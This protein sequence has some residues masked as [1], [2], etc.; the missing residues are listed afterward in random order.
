M[1]KVSREAVELMAKVTGG[2]FYLRQSINKGMITTVVGT[3]SAK[4]LVEVQIDRSQ[5]PEGAAPVVGNYTWAEFQAA[6]ACTPEIEIGF[7]EGELT[8]NGM[9]LTETDPPAEVFTHT[10]VKSGTRLFCGDKDACP[11]DVAGKI[12]EILPAMEGTI[13]VIEAPEGRLCLSRNGVIAIVAT[14][15]VTEDVEELPSEE[16]MAAVDAMIRSGA[17]TYEEATAEE[18]EEEAE[19]TEE[20][21]FDLEDD[22]KTAPAET[23]P[24]VAEAP[25]ATAP[26]EPAPKKT[27]AKKPKEVETMEETET[28]VKLFDGEVA[29]FQV[30]PK[31]LAATL[32]HVSAVCAKSK[33][34]LTLPGGGQKAIGIVAYKEPVQIKAMA[35][36][37]AS[38]GER[39]Q[40]SVELDK[41]STI[42]HGL[43]GLEDK[44]RFGITESEVILTGS[45]VHFTIPICSDDNLLNETLSDGLGIA[46]Y[47]TSFGAALRASVCA[48]DDKATNGLDALLLTVTNKGQNVELYSSDGVALSRA[49][50]KARSVETEEDKRFFLPLVLRSIKWPDDKNAAPVNFSFGERL[51]SV[52]IPGRQY[53]IRYKAKP[54]PFVEKILKSVTVTTKVFVQSGEVK[55][56]VGLLLQACGNTDK[57]VIFTVKGNAVSAALEKQTLTVGTFGRSDGADIKIG[58]TP[59]L[60]LRSMSAFNP[61]DILCVELDTPKSPVVFSN[62]E[63][64]L[65]VLQLPCTI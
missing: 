48:A 60:L 5:A 62:K 54:M 45:E 8:V 50:I 43:I 24:V 52:S 64:S 44:V 61:D 40:V 42:V 1:S 6:T 34:R 46:M 16:E 21:P 26:A 2:D 4:G 3:S 32:D 12:K 33:V 7:E 59:K 31:A 55:E 41:L 22:P 13:Q 58:F 18:S 37:D 47:P 23:K 36:V 14:P 10:A 57:P 20:I 27:P 17:A 15:I 9:A 51:F 39:L 49:L 38:A 19:P 53:L 25:Q 11:Q 30:A 29:A 28:I 65:Q 63:R 56:R 35:A